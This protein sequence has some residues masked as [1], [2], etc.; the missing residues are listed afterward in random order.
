DVEDRVLMPVGRKLKCSMCKHVFFQ[1][2]PTAAA[3]KPAAEE[4]PAP[5]PTEPPASLAEPPSDDPPPLPTPPPASEVETAPDDASTSP[6]PDEQGGEG[7]GDVD[8][9]LD[10]DSEPPPEGEAVS[11]ERSPER[12][13]DMESDLEGMPNLEEG[14]LDL[15]LDNVE[16][17]PLD[18]AGVSSA[19]VESGADAGE[20]E[21]IEALLKRMNAEDLTPPA[22]EEE[23]ATVLSELP[24]AG[25]DGGGMAADHG[26]DREPVLDD[27]DLDVQGDEELKEIVLDDLPGEDP[28][29]DDAETKISQANL[30]DLTQYEEVNLDEETVPS[31]HLATA[32][33]AAAVG[34]GLA[35][36]SAAAGGT[37]SAK[38]PAFAS[39]PAPVPDDRDAGQDTDENLTES[40]AAPR[41]PF[42]AP[43]IRR[44]LSW[45][46][47]FLGGLW[48]FGMLSRTEW[49]EYRLYALRNDVHLATVE[50][51]WRTTQGGD[52]M[53][54]L[55][56]KLHN[57]T[58]TSQRASMIR[59]SLLDKENNPLQAVRIVPGRVLKEEDFDLSD[60]SLHTLLELQADTQQVKSI[61]N[62]KAG[63][64]IGF[65]AIFLLP[66]EATSRFRV[67]IDDPKSSSGA[68][69]KDKGEKDAGGK[70]EKGAEEKKGH[71]KKGGH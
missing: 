15:D 57:A 20:E 13:L 52:A 50:S 7:S 64:D 26:E 28:L 21:S 44:L 23:E 70:H 40:A 31:S 12:P 11:P 18:D 34:A 1:M 58:Q 17:L 27:L 67:D 41:F 68:S 69:P 55:E 62:I 65:Q 9:D 30:N 63:Q 19:T 4:P 54:L 61:P 2:P 35:A 39:A 66:P 10:L 24:G 6:Q 60:E 14:D 48:V 16:D 46:A 51:R 5:A 29:A 71:E 32:A 59:V 25:R 56:G 45:T 33:A 49:F 3:R 42:E 38:S 22:E 53:L 43:H 36:A 37:S 47:V 8:L